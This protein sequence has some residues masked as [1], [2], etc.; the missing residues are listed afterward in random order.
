MV[1]EDW[2]AST[3]PIAGEWLV[4]TIGA[5]R[6]RDL[7]G[8]MTGERPP[9]YGA[10]AGRLRL[11][12]GDG[13]LPVGV[14][15]P[16]ERE[17]A[18]AM[19]LSRATVT[20]A[21]R[22]LREDGWADAR[23]GAGT[24]TRLPAAPRGGLW[25]PAPTPPGVIDLAHA[26]AAAPPEVPAAFSAALA[27][28]PRLL[29]GHGYHPLGLPELRARVAERY[30]A[31]GLPTTPEQVLVT[32]GALHGV[33]V[34]VETV[35]GRADR[36]LVEHP[37]YPNALDAIR[38][39]GRRSLPVAVSADD[40]DAAVRDLN[41]T[42]RETSPA[43]AYLM[44]DFQNPT[45][46]LLDEPQRRR[47]AVGLAQRDVV[48]VVDETLADLG[49]DAQPGVPFAAV[50]RPDLV[51]TA[52]TMSKSFWGGLRVGWLRAEADV[53]RR[54]A[55]VAGRA[56]MS[57]P[58]LEQLAA[59]HLL[60]A[61]DSV[62]AARRSALRAQRDALLGALARHLPA[63]R[64]TTPR[65]GLVVWCELPT[66]SSSALVS[67]A[68]QRGLLLAAGPRFGT[69]HSLDDRLRLPYT[70]PADV[71]E[72]GVRILADVAADLPLPRG[73]SPDHRIVV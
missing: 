58:V 61:A 3:M 25:L 39:L 37:S 27:D 47:L 5:A 11:L 59:C 17:L 22:R 68:E 54:L 44:P 53:V 21:Y 16:A 29:P 31:R 42:V 8:D 2:P 63:W 70:Q 52:G 9:L 56:Q 28:L 30:T 43:A 20:A 12:V 62:L 26:A 40:P 48:A 34:A 71:I 46:L 64:A 36:V 49:L 51:V 38:L 35:T 73:G 10:L 45:G 67:A 65:G 18:A 4:A 72:R 41:R 50:A 6:L 14:R 33:S 23:Q 57:G 55:A 13:R 32:G 66:R 60:D 15:L 7:V 24:W 1:A 19:G 69:G